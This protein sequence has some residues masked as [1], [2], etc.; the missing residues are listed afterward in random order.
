MILGMT[1]ANFTL[2]HVAIS[3]IG[4]VAGLVAVFGMLQGRYLKGT[5]TLFLVTTILT[6]VTGFF[7]P[8]TK[9]L[10]SHITGIIS[11]V[12]LAITVLALYTY[13]LAGSWRWIYVAGATLALYLNMFVLTVQAFL[14][15]PALKKLAPT[16]SEPPFLIAQGVLLIVFIALFIIA[17]R[18]F[19]PPTPAIR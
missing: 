10:P 17:V 16:Q 4:I 9:L 14:K 8:F 18:A 7:F 1:I 12:V 2:L 15:V 13:R 6:S 11:L 3:L 19:R 5:S